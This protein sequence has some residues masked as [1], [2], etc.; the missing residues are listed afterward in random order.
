MTTFKPEI[1]KE[2]TAPYAEMSEELHRE[3][4][5]FLRQESERSK[6]TR[7]VMLDDFKA[8]AATKEGEHG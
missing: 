8:D 1:M 5:A 7:I 2:L 4:I 3:F 6:P